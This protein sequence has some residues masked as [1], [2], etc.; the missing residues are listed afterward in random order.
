MI[1]FT[2]TSLL[3]FT[4]ASHAN[5]GPFESHVGSGVPADQISAWAIT[6]VDYSPTSEVVAFDSFGGGPWDRPRRGLG[7]ANETYV[8]LGDL[9]AAA[10]AGGAAPGSITV[11]FRASIF[12]GPGDDLVV[13][14][15]ASTFFDSHSPD[16]IFAELAYVEVSSNGVDFARFPSTSLNQE[17]DAS[18]PDP[19]LNQLYA[20]FGRDFAG[21]NTTNIDNLAGV[22]PVVTLPN[23]T[24][25]PTG[26]PFDLAD[27]ANDPLVSSGTVDV[28]SIR[29]VR[30]VD[31][32]GDGSFFDSAG[33]SILDAWKTVESGGFDLDAVGAIHAV[34]EPTL[35]VVTAFHAFL[36]ALLF[37]RELRP[38]LTAKR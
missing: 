36:G 2:L 30:L 11:A 25:M 22:H 13:F 1:R 21:V 16:F 31:I 12:D 6:L 23:G 7:P 4:I 33:N 34:P 17:V 20:P 28:D 24:R 32:P 27:L 26:T 35:A 14:E 19:D 3:L 38:K 9:D 29:Y 15:N 37:N 8:A 18:L 10:I 5:A